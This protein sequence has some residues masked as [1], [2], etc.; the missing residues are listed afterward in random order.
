MV[1]NSKNG[2]TDSLRLNASIVGPRGVKFFLN[3]EDAFALMRRVS[4]KIQPFDVLCQAEVLW[5]MP[6]MFSMFASLSMIC[7]GNIWLMCFVLPTSFLAEYFLVRKEFFTSSLCIPFRIIG[8]VYSMLTGY[9]LF[10]V[11]L[12][13]LAY[14]KMGWVGVCAYVA[15]NGIRIHLDARRHEKEVVY[16]A[17]KETPILIFDC[18]CFL[19]AFKRLAIKYGRSACWCIRPDK[20]SRQDAVKLLAE[21]THQYPKAASRFVAGMSGFVLPI[22]EMKSD[23]TQR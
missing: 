2:K 21:Y 13:C 22:S 11:G 14:Y 19:V 1:G 4:D 20:D 8:Y 7:T 5:K 17:K 6:G 10:F 9:G 18:A 23:Q 3:V 15:V 12:S 16:F